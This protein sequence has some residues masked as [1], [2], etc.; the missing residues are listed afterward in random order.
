MLGLVAKPSLLEAVENALLI[1]DEQARKKKLDAL[2]EAAMNASGANDT[3]DKGTDLHGLS[4]LVDA[5]V[6]LPD[7]VSAADV[8]DMAAYM[9]AMIPFTVK[10]IEQFC[11]I[12]ELKVGGTY[13]RTVYYTGPGPVIGGEPVCMFDNELIMADLKTS[14]RG[15]SY[16]GLKMATQLACYSRAK[17]YDYSRFPVEP[18]ANDPTGKKAL[19]A[20][21]KIERPAEEAAQAYGSIG[22]VN[23]DW[24]IIISL[25]SGSGEASLHWADLNK[26]WEM[27]KLAK[28]IR[29]ARSLKPLIPFS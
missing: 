19:A 3:R 18:V 26:G 14:K 12:G 25:P 20:W 16:G 24:G 8:S 9:L 22:P 29:A 13:D 28:T 27:A 15:V 10:D 17:T 11:V 4:E 1:E 21:K 23:Q 5:G 6:A 2:A 7:G